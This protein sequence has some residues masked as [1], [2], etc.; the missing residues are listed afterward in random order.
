MHDAGSK[1]ANGG[2]FF[3]A[4]ERSIRLNASSNVFP[5]GDHVR[6]LVTAIGAHRNLADQPVISL[7][8]FGHRLLLDTLSLSGCKHLAEFALEQVTTLL[9]KHVKN[10]S[11]QSFAARQAELAQLA[12]S[13]P[14][15]DAVVAIDRVKRQRQRIDDCLGKPLLHL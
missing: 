7:A 6:H 5:N 11:A 2:K 3:G 10:I 8:R 13:V 12:I 9:G 15:N 4:R 14:G 1:A